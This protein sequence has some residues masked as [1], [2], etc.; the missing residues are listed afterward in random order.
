MSTWADGVALACIILIS[1]VV[2]GDIVLAIL[3]GCWGASG[4]T[5]WSELLRE[6]IGIS[7]L[8]PWTLAVWTGHWFPI[9]PASYA[10]PLGIALPIV[11]A[12]T[13]AVTVVG[14]VLMRRYRRPVIPPWSLVL[15][16]LVVGG[17]LLP[18]PQ[19]Y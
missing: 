6:S 15:T 7:T 5:T 1:C 10:P 16:G 17:L 11:L 14:D 2:A 18:L 19:V 13:A 3:R 12:L 9:L 4:G 8:I